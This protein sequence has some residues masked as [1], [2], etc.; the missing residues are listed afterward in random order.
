MRCNA[1]IAAIEKARSRFKV[2]LRDG[3]TIDTA[4]VMYATGRSPNTA[5]IGLEA[6]GVKLGDNGQILVDAYS[7]PPSSTSTRSAT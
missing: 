7:R 3:D 2:T 6:A 1:E 5:G 4:K